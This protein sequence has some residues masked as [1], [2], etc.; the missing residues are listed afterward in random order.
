MPL[1]AASQCALCLQVTELRTS[2]L[3]PAFVGKYL[4]DTSATG[5]LRSGEKPNVRQQDTNKASLLCGKCE[6]IF[7]VFENEFSRKAFPIIQGDDFQGLNYDLWLLKFL[8]SIN[9][10]LLVTKQQEVVND[11][12]EFKNIILATLENWRLFLLGER[13]RAGGVHHMFV[14]SGVPMKITGDVHQKTLYYLL[15]GIDGSVIAFHRGIGVYTKLIRA[16]FYSPLVPE[17]PSGW[18][19]TRIHAGPGRIVSPQSVAMPGLSDYIQMR[20]QAMHSKPLS[21]TQ[22]QKISDAMLKNPERAIASES[23]KVH[24][25]TRRLLSEKAE[26]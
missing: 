25:A 11:S 8:V 22:R 19:N 21:E 12:P 9:W 14:I 1:K 10:R 5:Y 24:Q 3:V 6:G 2:H 26:V 15:R 16:M 18:K 20:I 17:S 4:K 23:F 7:S 13:N